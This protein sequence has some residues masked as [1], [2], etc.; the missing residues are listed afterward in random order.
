[1]ASLMTLLLD[2]SKLVSTVRIL[3]SSISICETFGGVSAH[4]QQAAW[5]CPVAVDPGKEGLSN[6]CPC[7]DNSPDLVLIIPFL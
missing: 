1:M 6:C 2:P 5:R 3:F 7:T 4:C